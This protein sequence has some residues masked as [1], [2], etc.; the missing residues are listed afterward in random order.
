[1]SKLFKKR[2]AWCAEMMTSDVETKKY[3]SWDCR[4][5]AL[6]EIKRCAV[7][8]EPVVRSIDVKHYTCRDCKIKRNRMLA[9]I[10]QQKKLL[11]VTPERVSGP[12]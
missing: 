7:C 4:A 1:M 10:R 3:C 5:K 12:T 9:R 11:T 2:C 6:A 8:D